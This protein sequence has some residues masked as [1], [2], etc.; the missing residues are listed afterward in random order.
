MTL[1]ALTQ[2]Q[3]NNSITEIVRSQK[4]AGETLDRFFFFFKLLRS[5]VIEAFGLIG[6]F[7][8]PHVST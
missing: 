5:L 1:Y 3:R 4:V 2:L 7:S 8:L 6:F